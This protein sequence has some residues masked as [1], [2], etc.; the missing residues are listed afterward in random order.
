MDAEK[1]TF[2]LVHL[3]GNVCVHG[4]LSLLGL[5]SIVHGLDYLQNNF[6]L[7]NSEKKLH[8]KGVGRVRAQSTYI[9]R[10]QSS[11]WRLPKY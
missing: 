4:V 2:L 6:L 9:C 10:V 8:I 3:L 7:G 1:A 11:F 5:C